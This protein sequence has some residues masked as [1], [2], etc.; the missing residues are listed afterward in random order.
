MRRKNPAK[1]KTVKSNVVKLQCFLDPANAASAT[2][3]DAIPEELQNISY[4]VAYHLLADASV[5]ESV[6]QV[7]NMAL[8]CTAVGWNRYW[9][10]KA[11]SGAAVDVAESADKLPDET[12]NEARAELA[13]QRI[14]AS[15]E[16]AKECGVTQLPCVEWEGKLFAGADAID[17]LVDALIAKKK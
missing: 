16:V 2:V 4:S 6:A 8:Q 7:Q 10:R 11:L 17:Q 5:P 14:E 9:V 15:V 3:F 1:S 12:P 13:T